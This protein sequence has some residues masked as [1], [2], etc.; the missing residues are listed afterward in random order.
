MNKNNT[1]LTLVAVWALTFALSAQPA[2]EWQ[3]CLGGSGTDQAYSIQQT[4]DGGYIVA[5]SSNSTGINGNH[6]GNDFFVAKLSST[7]TVTWQKCLGGSA[8]D[9]AHSVQQ[10]SD[11]GYVVAGSTGSNDGD[12]SGNHVLSGSGSPTID[13]WVVKL[14]STGN[15]VW[16][17]CLGGEMYDDAASVQQT[18]DGG[19]IVAGTTYN[20]DIFNIGIKKLNSTGG[21]EWEQD[22]IGSNWDYGFCV[23]QTADGGY[24]VAGTTDSDDMNGN[25]GNHG[26]KD[27]FIMKLSSTGSVQWQKYLGGSGYEDARAI[28]PTSDGG[29]IIAGYA[30]SN[31]GDVSG[32]HTGSG[33]RDGW[34]VKLN[35]SGTL[36][37]QKC[38]GGTFDEIAY[39]V[40][41]TDDGG[42]VVAGITSSTDGDVSGSNGGSDSW[43]VKLNS[44]GNIIWQKCLGGTGQ[45]QAQ[46]IQQTTGGGYIMAGYTNSNDGQV[47]GNN[48]DNDFWIVKLDNT[49]VGIPNITELLAVN[50]FPNPASTQLNIRYK[51]ISSEEAQLNVYDVSGKRAISTTVSSAIGDNYLRLNVSELNSGIYFVE[52]NQ[53]GH[54][55]RRQFTKR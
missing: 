36:E 21:V 8:E 22:Y 11:G 52:L 14:N 48:G 32:L 31:N 17:K 49:N 16:Q 38:L 44:S 41:Q 43:I 51:L 12:V 50:I 26:E 46:S 3:K 10:T 20:V 53:N 4:S 13:Y 19:Y 34:V 40:Q 23:K 37:W 5:G 7:G 1:L 9:I 25:S 24:V 6:G 18:S 54:S 39:A 45:E 55:S 30:D 35:S 28:Q 33:A 47:S 27:Y 2:I 42:Y 15:I 29:C